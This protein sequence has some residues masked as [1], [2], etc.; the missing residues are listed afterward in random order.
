MTFFFGGKTRWGRIR[1]KISL[2]T[3]F[4][5]KICKQKV[6]EKEKLGMGNQTGILITF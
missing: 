5:F 2:K 1:N 3:K 6:K 4:E